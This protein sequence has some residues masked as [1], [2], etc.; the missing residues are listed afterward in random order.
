MVVSTCSNI[1]LM[2]LNINI[3]TFSELNSVQ[4]MKCFKLFPLFLHKQGYYDAYDQ[5]PL[6]LELIRKHSYALR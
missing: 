1:C 3:V 5:F 2:C 4:K 6:R